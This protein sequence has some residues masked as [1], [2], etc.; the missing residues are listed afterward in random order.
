MIKK[1]LITGAG[2]Q[3]GWELARSLQGLGEVVAPSRKI[4]DL[5]D[6]ARIREV[7]REVSPDLIV[8]A[9]AYTAVDQAEQETEL[10]MAINGEAPGVLAG[11]AARRGAVLVH[12]ST[13]YVFDGAQREPYTEAA[14]PNPLNVYGR[15]KLAGEQAIAASGAAHVILRTSWVYG[16]RG[17]NF[18]LS[19][20]RA[21][22]SQ[23]E[24]RVVSD[25]Y[26]AP[27]WCRT[28]AELS[29]HI[30]AQGIAGGT[31][32]DW[33]HARSGIYHLSA[34]GRATW[35]DFAQL[36]VNRMD[37]AARPQVLPISAQEHA[38]AA[39]RPINSLLDNGKL[40]ETFG[41]RAPSWQAGLGLCL[42]I[43][44]TRQLA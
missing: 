31:G 34:Q 14:Q 9:A 12:Y 25:Q 21:A 22:R 36:I 23:A 33:W 24:L 4:L 28:V 26:G 15:S 19:I 7:V 27:T 43:E 37:L 17:R 35:H 38:A 39:E 29:A 11:E 6:A 40:A 20:M 16:L 2:G 3:V 5:R 41:L 30:V 18:L 13:D 44:L 8:N 32:P 1:I 42:G 10:A